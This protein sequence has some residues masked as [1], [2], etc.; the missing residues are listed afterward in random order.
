MPAPVVVETEWL[1]VSRLG[2]GAFDPIFED[3]GTGALRVLD[4]TMADWQRV[5]TL[6]AIYADLGLGL[7]DASVIVAAEKLNEE[8]IATLDRRHFSVV[9]PIHVEALRLLPD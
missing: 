7:V 8:T 5:R 4:L 1:V 6:C 9:R 3:M 2:E